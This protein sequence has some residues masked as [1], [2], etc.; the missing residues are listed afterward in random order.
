M[1]LKRTSISGSLFE[2]TIEVISGS[3]FEMTIEFEST[4]TTY[5]PMSLYLAGGFTARPDRVT[6]GL[7]SGLATDSVS[8]PLTTSGRSAD[9]FPL[10]SKL[11]GVLDQNWFANL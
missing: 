7:C 8:V 6:Y 1:M 9:S 11:S 2:M 3:L 10:P 5:F 4:V